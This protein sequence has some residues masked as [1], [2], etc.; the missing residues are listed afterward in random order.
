MELFHLFAA[1]RNLHLS[2]ELAQPERV[3]P[4]WRACQGQSTK[5]RARFIEPF[6]KGI[7]TIWYF[8]TTLQLS[9]HP[10]TVNR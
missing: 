6:R 1:V 7:P 2:E 9:A 3:E 4:A 8:V 5:R 10:I